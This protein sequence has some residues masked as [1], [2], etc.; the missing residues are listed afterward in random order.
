MG[1][2]DALSPS[3]AFR[4]VLCLGVEAENV[5]DMATRFRP[6]QRQTEIWIEI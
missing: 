2:K 1:K 4:D 5:V 6:S 3:N